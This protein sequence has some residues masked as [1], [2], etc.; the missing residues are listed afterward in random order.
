MNELRPGL[1]TRR[2]AAAR[3]VEGP[4]LHRPASA[5][6]RRRQR[7]LTAEHQVLARAHRA[8]P[9]HQRRRTVPRRGGA[10][11]R[12]RPRRPRR[13]AIGTTPDR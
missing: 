7:H 8:G 3:A 11:Q 10:G 13:C 6:H 5:D 2:E 9:G 12:A 4:G 1:V